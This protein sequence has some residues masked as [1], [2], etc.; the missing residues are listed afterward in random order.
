MNVSRLF[1]QPEEII[2]SYDLTKQENCHR[3]LDEQREQFSKWNFMGSR[4]R[5]SSTIS[6][7]LLDERDGIRSSPLELRFAVTWLRF[8]IDSSIE[9][10]SL[11]LDGIH[12]L[13]NMFRESH[14]RRF[15]DREFYS[16][17]RLYRAP[18][19]WLI[20]SFWR[21]FTRHPTLGPTRRR[22]ATL[23]FYRN[24]TE[25]RCLRSKEST[26]A[27]TIRLKSICDR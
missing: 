26:L 24:C 5:Q 19:K 9:Y 23:P 12:Q 15:S 1:S 3:T 18:S 25:L 6:F 22:A 21:Q 17:R 13:R 11:I 27:R 14:I 2:S 10:R 7:L 16:L 8:H 20:R 4:R